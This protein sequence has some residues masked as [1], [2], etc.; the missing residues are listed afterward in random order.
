MFVCLSSLSI[1]NIPTSYF[2]LSFTVNIQFHV[3]HWNYQA[4]LFF[5]IFP[6]LWIAS[7]PLL[8]TSCLSQLPTTLHGIHLQ[9]RSR[10]HKVTCA[11]RYQ[12]TYDL[13]F[14]KSFDAFSR[15]ELLHNFPGW[16]PAGCFLTLFHS[17]CKYQIYFLLK[18]IRKDKTDVTRKRSESFEL[19]GSIKRNLELKGKVSFV[20][21]LPCERLELFLEDLGP[22]FFPFSLREHSCS[23]NVSVH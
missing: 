5:L 2:L 22:S 21:L 1:L 12:I 7:V 16:C 13:C 15:D 20:H 11:S 10:Q 4:N 23:L 19:Y 18:I 9:W 6:Y 17:F 8:L 3:Y 14:L